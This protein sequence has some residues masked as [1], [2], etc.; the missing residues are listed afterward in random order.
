M[1]RDF[2]DRY[3]GD[4][5]L[6]ADASLICVDTLVGWLSTEAYWS[7]GRSRETIETSIENSFVYGVLDE[8]GEMVAFTRVVTDQATIAWVSDVFVEEHH[9]GQGIGTWMVG[10]LTQFWTLAGV[11]RFL[12]V[13]RDAHG[14]Y[15]KVGFT[16]LADPS[17]FMEIDRR[18][19]SI[20]EI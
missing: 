11:P 18:P 19:K 10:E 5:R 4:L 14:V 20:E 16:P 9:R 3:R 6:T 12:L 1:F 17:R 7:L 13:T 8:G 2:V 15:E